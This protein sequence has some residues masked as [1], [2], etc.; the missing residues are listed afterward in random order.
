MTNNNPNIKITASIKEIA[1]SQAS[2]KD[3]GLGV[4]VWNLRII[5]K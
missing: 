1:S 3:L 2:R 5:T 4:D